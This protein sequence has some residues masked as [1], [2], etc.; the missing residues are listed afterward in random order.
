MSTDVFRRYAEEALRE[1]VQSKNEKEQ[2]ALIELVRTWTQAAEATSDSAMVFS[3]N[4]GDHQVRTAVED[5]GQQAQGI[6][7]QGTGIWPDSD[8]SGG[9]VLTVA[10]FNFCVRGNLF[11]GRTLY[12]RSRG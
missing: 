10:G 7:H 5:Q 3:Y 1:A 4:P 12:P 11:F 8:R 9:L 6:G 2:L